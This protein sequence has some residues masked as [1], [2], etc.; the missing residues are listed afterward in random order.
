MPFTKYG[1]ANQAQ[2]QL[3]AGISASATSAILKSGQG[4]LFPPSLECP[5][6]IKSEKYDTALNN[7]RVLK[8]ELI[9][10][11]NRAGDVLTI[12]R[13]A[14]YCPADYAATTQT[15]TA[16]SFDADDTITQV[17]IGEQIEEIQAAVEG[18]VDT[19]AGLRT[20]MTANGVMGTDGSGNEVVVLGAG[21]VASGMIT[22]YAG[23][24]APAGFLLCD[25]SAVSRTT[26]AALFSV[27]STT[28]G[29]GDGS[30]TFNLP[31]LK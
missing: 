22:P 1:V 15:N 28:Y 2:G 8:R 20:G 14:G 5:F 23:A 17:L 24:S 30:T 16:F 25:G 26:Y 10:V 19:V 29:A 11:T 18:K 27:T 9:K 6:Y 12:E 21:F 13:S 4:A 3:Q 7:F 31:N